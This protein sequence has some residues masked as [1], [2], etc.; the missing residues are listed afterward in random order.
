MN[1]RPQ[2]PSALSSGAATCPVSAVPTA[3]RKRFIWVRRSLR[4]LEFCLAL[5]GLTILLLVAT[6][7]TNNLYTALNVEQPPVKSKYI[8]CLGGDSS[9]IIEAAR[10]LQEGY[11]DYLIVTNHGPFAE[12][13]RQMAV[14]WGAD[15]ARV[16]VDD[17][18]W[19][20]RDHAPSIAN[21]LGVDPANDSFIIVTSYAHM[22]RSKA[23]F[24]K[25]GY[26]HVIMRQPRWERE[27]AY[28]RKDWKWRIRV[29]PNL[30]YEYAA[31]VEYT[32][33]GD[34]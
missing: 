26:R 16:L 18:S 4:L 20:T 29:L 11:G 33:R 2:G 30:I 32:L 5:F 25:A 34:V 9:R 3:K 10:L 15:P 23:C 27:H 22:A 6:P 28:P 13:M 7:L 31:W 12:S 17:H 19:K 8:V 24:E 1:E 21:R 14:Q